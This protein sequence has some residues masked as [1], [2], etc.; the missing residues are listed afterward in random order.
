MGCPSL[1]AAEPRGRPLL[2]ESCQLDV[3]HL[4]R[5][6]HRRNLYTFSTG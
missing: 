1:T 6:L 5:H 3:G 4:L 2:R